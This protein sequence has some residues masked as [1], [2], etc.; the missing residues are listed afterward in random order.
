MAGHTS[1]QKT[2]TPGA[3]HM[4]A[5]GDG[6]SA[7]V[8]GS[9]R[10]DQSCQKHART[11]P[12]GNAASREACTWPPGRSP[13]AQQKAVS[14]A[15]ELQRLR[16]HNDVRWVGRGREARACSR[17]T[18]QRRSPEDCASEVAT[19]NSLPSRPPDFELPSPTSNSIPSFFHGISFCE[20]KMP[21]LSLRPTNGT[22]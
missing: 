7:L 3:E 11:L 14:P 2:L 5:Q 8:N 21:D 17:E 4:L 10:S 18:P 9:A 22:R 20:T 19:S 6:S 15:E 1:D 13:A 16:G 12:H